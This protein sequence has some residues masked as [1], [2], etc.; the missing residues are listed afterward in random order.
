MNLELVFSLASLMA[1]VGWLTLLLSPLM[2]QWSDRIAGLII[3]LLLSL[4][5]VILVVFFSPDSDGGFGSLADVMKLFSQREAVLSGWLHFLAFDL[6]IGAWICRT[7]RRE[8]LNFW[9]VIP[10]LLL[11]FLFGPAGYLAFSLVRISGA[12][13]MPG[14]RGPR[15]VSP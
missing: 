7:A 8:G 11:T 15:G 6:L 10:C 5:Y 4:G 14:S 12:L 1:M 9:P 3:P 2:P 13:R